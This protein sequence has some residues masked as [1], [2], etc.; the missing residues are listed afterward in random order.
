MGFAARA[1]DSLAPQVDGAVVAAC[2]TVVAV[3]D[4]VSAAGG[5][6]AAAGRARNRYSTN[7]GLAILRKPV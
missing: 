3:D 2:S 6:V 4:A 1:A 5:T 7:N